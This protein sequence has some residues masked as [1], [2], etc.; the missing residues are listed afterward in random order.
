VSRDFARILPLILSCACADSLR[1]WGPDLAGARRGA[2]EAAAA[3]SYRFT[4]VRRDEKFTRAR[5]AMGQY[6]L[7][8][9]RLYRDTSL[10]TIRDSPD[11]SHA[12][13]L[14]AAL[15]REGYY[16]RTTASAPYPA[17]LGG[18]RHYIRLRKLDDSG[19]EWI[20]IVDHGI[21]TAPASAVAAGIGRLLTGFEGKASPE[22][23]RDLAATLT[24]SSQQFGRLLRIDSLVSVPAADGSTALTL[25]I[26]WQP[27]TL[28][29]SAPSF[30]AW[31]D[32]YVMPADFSIALVDTKGSRFLSLVGTPGRMRIQVRAHQGRWVA[33]TGLPRPMPDSLEIHADASVKFKVFRVGFRRLIGSFVLERGAHDRGFAMKWRQE[34]EW[35]FPLAANR[36]IRTPLR[37]P[38]AGRGIE[39]RLGVRDD[40]GSQTMSLRHVRLVV[41]ESAI[42]RWLGGLGATAFGDYEGQTEV[43]ENRFLRAC[44][45]A[46]RRDV[47][48]ANP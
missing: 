25:S 12:L 8:P 22:V 29:R 19:F 45:E 37:T 44:F 26:S 41:R 39:L 27:D 30:A 48:A 33:L 42:M 47:A 34:P 14:N 21:G 35:R 43:E 20:T 32:K 1:P 40:L 23:R 24:R 15:E 38:F 4:D 6:A 17:A 13:Y 31:I 46:L 11:S 5:P 36:L 16:F 10:W 7:A 3:F 2:D 28:R 18:E 9:S